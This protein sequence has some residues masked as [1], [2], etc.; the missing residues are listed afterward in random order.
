[1]Q[2]TGKLGDLLR[3]AAYLEML[4]TP[5]HDFKATTEWLKEETFH[6]YYRPKLE[7]EA[8]AKPSLAPT[9]KRARSLVKVLALL[10]PIAVLLAAALG[11]QTLPFK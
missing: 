3:N 6:R 8:T 9:E 1:V 2:L 7:P 5:L 11:W 4:P 10:A